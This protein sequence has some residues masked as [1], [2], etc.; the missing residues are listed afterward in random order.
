M[1]TAEAISATLR[2]AV[3]TTR[4]CALL[5]GRRRCCRMSVTLER[6]RFFFPDVLASLDAVS[7]VEITIRHRILASYRTY[8]L[9]ADNFP[10]RRSWTT[11]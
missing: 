11:S 8:R 6:E 3:S 10:V 7:A 9:S 2:L 4:D 5:L 1:T